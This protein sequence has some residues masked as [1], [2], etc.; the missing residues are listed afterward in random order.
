MIATIIVN[1]KSNKDTINF[2][3]NELVKVKT[4]N[5][6]IVVNNQAT[7]KSDNNF[8][9]HLNAEI[10]ND[11]SK[12][13]SNK[14][15]CFI[16]SEA[17]NIGFAKGNNLG[18]QFAKNHFKPDFLLFTNND[19]QFI[20]D[21]VV[22]KLI[23]KIK[24]LNNAAIIGPRIIGTKG[25]NQSPEPFVSFMNRYF[26]V[27][28]STPFLSKKSKKKL[29]NI[30][31]SKNAAEGFHYKIM[32]SFF[33][34]KTKDFFE[35]GMM[36]PNTFLYAE[37]II[38]SERLKKIN[39]RAYYY[40]DVSVLHFHSKTISSNISSKKKRM[41]KFTSE[42]YYYTKYIG[43]SRITV[44]LVKMSFIFYNFLKNI[45]NNIVN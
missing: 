16:I 7:T 43:V 41:I 35:C 14:K 25:E 8:K 6:V 4:P 33:L 38:L 10:I 12:P 18:S 36:D 21:N 20:S 32:G 37:E 3:N 2:V 27:Y 28:W 34:A 24:C 9:K 22:E 40:P 44:I 11:I 17:K 23:S 30:E 45:K 42:S 39:K 19:I 15:S 1:Y 31:Y 13:I 5:I 26:W 29:F